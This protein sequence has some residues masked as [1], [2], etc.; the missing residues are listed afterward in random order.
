MHCTA[1]TR[2]AHCLPLLL[3]PLLSP[4]PLPLRSPPP[5]PTS[6]PPPPPRGTSWACRPR[7][8]HCCAVVGIGIVI[9]AVTVAFSVAIALACLGWCVIAQYVLGIAVGLGEKV[10]DFLCQKN[11]LRPCPQAQL[12]SHKNI[13]TYRS[14]PKKGTFGGLPGVALSR[15]G[16][17]HTWTLKKNIVSHIVSFPPLNY[18]PSVLAVLLVVMLVVVLLCRRHRWHPAATTTAA[19]AVGRRAG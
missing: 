1:A 9:V 6:P 14:R 19:T 11:S 15:E 2:P 8:C 13:K 3:P 5:P 7:R 18:P 4:L 16:S 12:F 10:C 17:R